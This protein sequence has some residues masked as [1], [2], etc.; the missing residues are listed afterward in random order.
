MMVLYHTRDG[1]SSGF[2]KFAQILEMPPAR[3]RSP[4]AKVVLSDGARQGKDKNFAFFP[5]TYCQL[6]EIMVYFIQEQPLVAMRE[7]PAGKEARLL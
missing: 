1:L 4:F 3:L 6:S 5:E 7:A 2:L